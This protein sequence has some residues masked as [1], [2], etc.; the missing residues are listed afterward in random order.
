MRLLFEGMKE[1][2]RAVAG[3]IPCRNIE[4]ASQGDGKMSKI[5]ANTYPLL[6]SV[7][8]GAV[9]SS[10]L[11][12]KTNVAVDKITNSLDLGPTRSDRGKS[13]PGKIQQFA[14]NLAVTA[15]QNKRQSIRRNL[16]QA[17]FFGFGSVGVWFT[18]VANDGVI[19]KS[20]S[21]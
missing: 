16:T 18:A 17:R 19:E 10:H 1:L 4:G 5:T 2:E 8:R 9:R 14:V 7:Q 3:D 20:D 15:R 13:L 21:A 6:E 11:I 12:V